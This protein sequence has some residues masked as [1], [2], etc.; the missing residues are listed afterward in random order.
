[1]ARGWQYQHFYDDQSKHKSDQVQPNVWCRGCVQNQVTE[2]KYEDR[3]RVASCM[4]DVVRSEKD[5]VRLALSSILPVIAKA[6]HMKRHLSNCEWTSSHIRDRARRDLLDSADNQSNNGTDKPCAKRPQPEPV[7][8]PAQKRIKETHPPVVPMP[9]P[10]I[11]KQVAADHLSHSLLV[12]NLPRNATNNSQSSHIRDGIPNLIN[13][14]TGTD[15]PGVKRA[16][17]EPVAEQAQKRAKEAHSSAVSTPHPRIDK[18][19]VASDPLCRPSVAVNVGMKHGLN[20][21][22]SQHG[23]SRGEPTAAF[24]TTPL[25]I[26]GVEVG[27]LTGI[28]PPSVDVHPL[29]RVLSKKHL[30]TTASSSSSLPQDEHF[31]RFRR[32]YGM[33]PHIY[34]TEHKERVKARNNAE[35]DKKMDVFLDIQRKQGFE[36]TSEDFMCSLIF[37]LYSWSFDWSHDRSTT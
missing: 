2:W 16:Q 26:E 31:S 6:K 14:G 1:M 13:D 24:A 25:I 15:Q 33:R 12:D 7:T 34:Q 8:E 10:K 11:D 23:P 5:L 36:G 21:W 29:H 17:P 4:I 32:P 20:K 28:R 37:I 3:A 35:L 19:A 27:L 18:Q 30:R 22:R 9:P